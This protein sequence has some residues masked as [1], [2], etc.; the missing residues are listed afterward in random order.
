MGFHRMVYSQICD[1]KV[2]ERAPR[3]STRDEFIHNFSDS[4]RGKTDATSMFSGGG[5]V[6]LIPSWQV[7]RIEYFYHAAEQCFRNY[8]VHCEQELSTLATPALGHCYQYF[9]L[10]KTSAKITGQVEC[11]KA[12]V[13][14]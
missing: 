9:L 7:T 8:P 3:S 13:S 10:R 1:L 12:Q 6:W 4:I 14:C 2:K 11:L 5:N